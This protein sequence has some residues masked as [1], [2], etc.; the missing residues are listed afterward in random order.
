MILGKRRLDWCRKNVLMLY[1]DKP[2]CLKT[3][4]N[5]LMETPETRMAKLRRILPHG[6]F[7][8]TRGWEFLWN[9]LRQCEHSCWTEAA[10]P[11]FFMFTFGWSAHETEHQ[12]QGHEVRIKS[13][14]LWFSRGGGYWIPSVKRIRII[15]M[16]YSVQLNSSWIVNRP[17]FFS[18]RILTLSYYR[19]QFHHHRCVFHVI[20]TFCFGFKRCL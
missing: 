4:K 7:E 6:S 10:V 5:L 13:Y 15:C 18:R 11:F 19:F 9:D 20:Q 2:M 16:S 1:T 17:L 3:N 8:S 12:D 14:E